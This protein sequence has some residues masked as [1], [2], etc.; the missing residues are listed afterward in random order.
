MGKAMRN[1]WLVAGLVVSLVVNLA[2]AGFVAG[3][4]TRDFAPMPG[5]D[6]L[7]GVVR[8]VR[9][10]DDDRRREVMRELWGKRREF[11]T[12]LRAIRGAQRAVATAVTAEPFDEEALRAAF[13]EFRAQLERSQADSHE[14]LATIAARLT[15][16]ERGRLARVVAGPGRHRGDRPPR[17]TD[18]AAG[19]DRRTW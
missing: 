1:R 19:R 5:F 17:E 7:V 4:L 6:P 2:L 18:G 16:E 13:A 8:L 14:M 10:L 11:R 3:R 15:P 12:S 9:F